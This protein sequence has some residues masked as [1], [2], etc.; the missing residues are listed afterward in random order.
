MPLATL[1]LTLLPPHGLHMYGT[2]HISYL[3]WD[4]S[5]KE[6]SMEPF[7][8]NF[9][10]FKIGL[11]LFRLWKDIFLTSHSAFKRELSQDALSDREE[12]VRHS[13]W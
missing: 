7:E 3:N 9:S 8:I 2:L 11:I 5:L 13:A 4:E 12:V 6:R 1:H 10:H